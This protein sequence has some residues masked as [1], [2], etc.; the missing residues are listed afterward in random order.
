M[1]NSEAVSKAE[2][3]THVLCTGPEGKAALVVVS[4]LSKATESWVTVIQDCYKRVPSSVK[5]EIK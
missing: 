4:W 3:R 2:E 1:S 5:W